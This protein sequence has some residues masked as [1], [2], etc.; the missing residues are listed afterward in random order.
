MTM[1]V[2]PYDGRNAARVKKEV[3]LWVGVLAHMERVEREGR[4]AASDHVNPL[5]IHA[6]AENLQRCCL[7]TCPAT[8]PETGSCPKAVAALSSTDDDQ[9]TPS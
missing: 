5:Q 2:T 6:K 1:S 8:T 7:R 4:R 3:L 9:Y